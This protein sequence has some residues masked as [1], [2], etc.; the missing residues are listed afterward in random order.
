MTDTRIS[1]RVDPKL[2]AKF[3]A[4]AKKE[5]RTRSGYIRWLMQKEVER[6]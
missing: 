2:L 3:D 1:T 6:C 5:G 4:L